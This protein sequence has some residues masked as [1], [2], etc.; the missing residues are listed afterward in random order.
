MSPT[1]TSR[2]QV[3]MHIR[4][5]PN[6]APTERTIT[7][8]VAYG[9]T[10]PTASDAVEGIAKLIESANTDHPYI[11]YIGIS[12]QPDSPLPSAP[13]NPQ[14]KSDPS[15]LSDPSEWPLRWLAPLIFASIL[16]GYYL[17]KILP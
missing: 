1:I 8:H 14:P 12:I 16:I 9:G 4:S 13:L 10:S 6:A 2:V 3:T 5:S 17:S 7:G 11:D 15:E